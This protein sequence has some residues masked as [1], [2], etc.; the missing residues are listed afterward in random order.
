MVVKIGELIQSQTTSGDSEG[1]KRNL[2]EVECKECGVVVQDFVQE[3]IAPSFNIWYPYFP[4]CSPCLE[5]LENDTEQEL[6]PNIGLK[7]ES[8]F[9]QMCPP[10]MME[11]DA[12]RLNQ[13]VLQRAMG[14]KLDRKGILLHGQTGTG[15]TRIM[16]LLVRELIVARGK[17]VR[18]YNSADL[19]EKMIESYRNKHSQQEML[20]ILLS[21]DILCIDDLG[22]E[23]MTDAWKELLF[24]V[25]DKRTL[26]HRPMI[27]TTNYV[28]KSF[29]ELFTDKNMADPVIRRLREFFVDIPT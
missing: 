23:K 3:C 18:V 28:G 2:G 4:V 6:E 13:K 7:L 5:K 14:E 25:I 24:N 16:W 20:S 8:D 27:I 19:K 15:K 17:S 22:K 9:S 29:S 1:D 21:C 26:Y 12:S 10:E 11:T